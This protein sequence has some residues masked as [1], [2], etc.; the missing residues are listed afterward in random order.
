MQSSSLPVPKPQCPHLCNRDSD[1]T[2]LI[3]TVGSH[4]VQ[5]ALHKAP[6]T[7]E[8]LAVVSFGP[9]SP[10][11]GRNHAPFFVL[12]LS[13]QKAK[14]QT[15]NTGAFSYNITPT[16]AIFKWFIRF[17]HVTSIT[18]IDTRA[19]TKI[20]NFLGWYFVH[21]RGPSQ[22]LFSYSTHV[23]TNSNP[24]PCEECMDNSFWRKIFPVPA[25]Y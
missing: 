21:G 11:D 17:K 3:R 15:E 1:S 9:R 13:N 25:Y 23:S 20:Q 6:G 8:M 4:L 5:W 7:Q 19:W 10:N 16:Q 18:G 12:A 24:S 2:S 14:T 22:L